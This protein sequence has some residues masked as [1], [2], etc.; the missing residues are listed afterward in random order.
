M[1]STDYSFVK[2]NFIFRI[3]VINFKGSIVT[4]KEESTLY[5]KIILCFEDS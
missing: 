4:E 2:I 1:Y 3:V 5:F